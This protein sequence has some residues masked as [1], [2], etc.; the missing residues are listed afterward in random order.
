MPAKPAGDQIVT[1]SIQTP[2]ADSDKAKAAYQKFE[3]AFAGFDPR[4][5][6]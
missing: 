2:A 3:K 1:L 4:S 5:G 6:S